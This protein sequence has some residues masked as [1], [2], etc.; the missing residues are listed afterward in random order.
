MSLSRRVGWFPHVVNQ[1]V[2]GGLGI[3]SVTDDLVKIT[4]DFSFS[5]LDTFVRVQPVR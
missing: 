5:M 2:I 3:F 4:V 1:A